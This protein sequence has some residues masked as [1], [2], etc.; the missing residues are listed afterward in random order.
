[1]TTVFEKN[2]NQQ[3]RPASVVK[4][5]TALVFND[6]VTSAMLDTTV[7]FNAADAANQTTESHAGLMS[8]DILSYRDLLYAA[9]LPSGNDA[10]RSIA[11]NVGAL[12]IAGSGPGTSG[13][14]TTRFVQAMN[15]KAT[16]LGMTS[17]TFT[18]SAGFDVGNVTTPADL[19]KAMIAVA[20]DGFLCGVMGAMSHTATIT[21]PNART[22]T[23]THTVAPYAGAG[24][25]VPIPE[26][27]AAKTGTVT[28]GPGYEQYNSG[29]CLAALWELPGGGR[30]VSVILGAA[31]PDPDRY[32]DLRRLIDYEKARVGLL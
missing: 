8:G 16:A 20:G 24:G 1:M 21:G 27:I 3:Q 23:W 15:A 29:G 6:W 25:S 30:R 10:A 18:D 28:Y 9:M 5:V 7:T 19:A 31:L 2:P 13:T 4:V 11:R 32:R 22:A 12:I 14:D 26:L 17:S